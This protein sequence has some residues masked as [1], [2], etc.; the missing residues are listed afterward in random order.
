VINFPVLKSHN[1]GGITLSGKNHF[2]SLMRVPTA[3]G[4]YNMHLTRATETPG[5][6]NYRAIVDLMAHPKLGAKTILVLIDG[7]YSGRS[8]DSHPIRWNM[9]PFNGDWPSSIFLSQDPVAADSVAFDFMHHEWDAIPT[10]ING[11]P[12]KSGA[13]DYSTKPR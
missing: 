8:W 7:L 2:G 11:Y 13:D 5:N 10:N 3:A 9:P 12:Q 6:G 1:D 4:Y